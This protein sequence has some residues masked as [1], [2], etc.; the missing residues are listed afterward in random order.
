VR[1][2][3]EKYLDAFESKVYAQDGE[4]FWFAWYPVK[5]R[6]VNKWCWLEKVWRV[7]ATEG[8][9][10]VGYWMSKKYYSEEP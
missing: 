1:W 2:N 4:G 9:E 8:Y 10:Y 5:L 6:D 3:F 7:C